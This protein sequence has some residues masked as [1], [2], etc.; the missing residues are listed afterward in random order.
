MRMA[1]RNSRSYVPALDLFSNM[2]DA[3][4]ETP[5][6]TAEILDNPDHEG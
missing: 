1:R 3:L 4:I 2:L 6:V 5:P